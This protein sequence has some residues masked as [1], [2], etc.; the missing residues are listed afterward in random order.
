MFFKILA[1]A[2]VILHFLWILFLIF[3]GLLVV[4]NTCAKV[5]HIG[6]LAF[7]FI[8]HLFQWYC[9]LT[10]LEV[11]LRSKHDPSLVYSGS[12]IVYYVE[13]IVYIEL[14][15]TVIFVLTAFLCVFN[16][17]LYLRKRRDN[18]QSYGESA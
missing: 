5:L 13:K 1:D 17:W 12:F 14:S 9:P 16:A 6:G 10:Y 2:V 3:G 4:R 18:R 15:R 8:I 7:A 11:W